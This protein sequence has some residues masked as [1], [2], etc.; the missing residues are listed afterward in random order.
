MENASKAL[1]MA[2]TVLLG[3]MIISIG[4]YLFSTYAGYSADAYKKMEDTQIAQFNSQF[5]KYYGTTT[6]YYKDDSGKEIEETV[7]VKSTAHDIISLANLAKQNNIK[8]QIDD[9]IYSNN[10]NNYYIQIDI[11]TSNNTKHIENWDIDT[12]IKFLKDYSNTEYKC[13]DIKIS[14]ITKRVYYMKFVE[15]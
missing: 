7:Q 1:I 15:K 5:L 4:V 9:V 8:N 3:V 11:G 13:N 6:R 14:A 12:Q 10:E 2:A